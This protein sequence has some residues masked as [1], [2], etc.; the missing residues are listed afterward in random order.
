MLAT[1]RRRLSILLAAVTLLGVAGTT[2][3]VDAAKPPLPRIDDPKNDVQL[4]EN[5]AETGTPADYALDIK[6][7]KVSYTDTR[8]KANVRF[9]EPVDDWS[10]VKL[11]IQCT[12]CAGG[13]MATGGFSG[14]GSLWVA[15][16]TPEGPEGL[17]DPTGTTVDCM[18]KFK[19]TASRKLMRMTIPSSCFGAP[20]TIDGV[21]TL[22]TADTPEGRYYADHTTGFLPL[23]RR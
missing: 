15:A 23:I 11:L 9:Y 21:Q 7:M 2:S 10:I 17:F 13:G 19:V 20:A 8:L 12:G 6:W 16:A 3:T 5:Q 1:M 4:F 18:M 22:I 14:E